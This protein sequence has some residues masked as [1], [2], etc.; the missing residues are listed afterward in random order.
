M[1][2]KIS[3]GLYFFYDMEHGDLVLIHIG[4]MLMTVINTRG[5]KIITES[6]LRPNINLSQIDRSHIKDMFDDMGKWV[7]TDNIWSFVDDTYKLVLDMVNC[8][9]VFENIN[10][11]I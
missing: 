6:T 8:R 9:L 3:N 11:R 5:C 7:R 10:G 1:Y 4:S 2:Q